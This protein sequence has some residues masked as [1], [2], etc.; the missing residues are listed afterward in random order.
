MKKAVWSAIATAAGVLLF[1]TSAAAQTTATVNVTVNVAA[2][3]L[4]T[5][6]TNAMTFADADPDSVPTLTAGA[7]N[8]AVRTRTPA[9]GAVN[10]TVQATGDLSAGGG[11]TIPINQLTWSATGTGYV[12]GVSATT[13]QT[14]GAWTGS[15]NR[16]GTQTYSLPN[17]WDYATGTYTTTLNYTLSVP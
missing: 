8:I 7:I 6:D 5:L 16:A 13:A 2:R 10:L 15:G 17:S 12:A 9:A 3:A 14:V 4:L 11:A 1:T